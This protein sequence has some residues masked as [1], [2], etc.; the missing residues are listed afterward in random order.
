M[1]LLP[2]VLQIQV[3]TVAIKTYTT[4]THKVL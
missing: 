4:D 3:M 2:I 1:H